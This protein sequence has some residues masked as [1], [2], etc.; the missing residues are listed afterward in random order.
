MQQLHRSGARF[1]LGLKGWAAIGVGFTLVV[2]MSLLAIGLFIFLLP[3]LILATILF[4]FAHKSKTIPR[5]VKRSAEYRAPQGTVIDG[6]F[7]VID[8]GDN[9]G[10]SGPQ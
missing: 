8:N 7:R 4:F 9:N 10:Q 3:V 6:E 2:A 1:Q 5:T